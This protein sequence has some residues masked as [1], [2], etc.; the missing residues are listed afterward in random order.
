MLNIY[1]VNTSYH[2]P[3]HLHAHFL[4]AGLEDPWKQIGTANCALLIQY[5]F[6]GFFHM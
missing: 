3:S 5:E 4:H 1:N 2:E 6:M